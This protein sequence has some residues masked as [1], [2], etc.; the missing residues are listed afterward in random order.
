MKDSP[1]KA[2]ATLE[3]LLS[4]MQVVT[5]R[6]MLK[7]QEHSALEAAR[8]KVILEEAIE[9]EKRNRKVKPKPR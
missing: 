7:Q 2:K 6:H 4:D 1:R 9:F 3:S 8:Q 5:G